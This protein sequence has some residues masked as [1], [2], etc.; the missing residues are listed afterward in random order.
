MGLNT[1]IKISRMIGFSDVPEVRNFRGKFVYNFFVRDELYNEKG[2]DR[3]QGSLEMISQNGQPLLIDNFQNEIDA[4]VIKSET[5]RF[6]ELDYDPA[7]LYNESNVSDLS[8]GEEKFLLKNKSLINDESSMNSPLDSTVA[9]TDVNLRRR[10]VGKLKILRDVMSSDD[11]PFTAKNLLEVLEEADDVDS[12]V[13]ENLLSKLSFTDK[14]FVNEIR[15]IDRDSTFAKAE[16]F[17][18]FTNVDRRVAA[19]TFNPVFD[20]NQAMVYVSDVFRKDNQQNWKAL[21]NESQSANFELNVKVLPGNQKVQK[22]VDSGLQFQ[23]TTAGYIIER[24]VANKNGVFDSKS[25]KTHYIDGA[26]R[27]KFIDTKVIYNKSYSYTVSAVYAVNF[28]A[29][30]EDDPKTT[31]N[32]AGTYKF[33][34]LVRSKRSKPVVIEAV[35]NIPP[36]APDGVLYRYNYDHGK[37][38]LINWQMPVGKQRDIKYFQVFRRRSIKE[39]F[40][41]IAELDFNDV[42]LRKGRK[43]LADPITK[44]ERVRKDRIYKYEFPRIFFNDARFDRESKFI[45]A[46]AAV[47]AHGLTSG[48]SAQTEVGFN[49]VKN[50]LTLST[51][52]RSGAA[53]QYPNFFIDP[54]LDDNF[55]VDSLTTDVMLSSKKERIHVFFDPDCRIAEITQDETSTLKKQKERTPVVKS[56]NKLGAEYVF[57]I[58]NVDRQK[59]K[60]FKIKITNKRKKEDLVDAPVDSV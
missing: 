56:M 46:I 45:Y 29:S 40:T 50:A 24:M 37:G 25:K 8:L 51:I 52:S 16:K 21:R 5:A 2:E 1:D 43:K 18:R 44:K 35:E 12:K 26:D 49:K 48:Y 39:P 41:C 34:A 42:I 31:E 9:K 22:S 36:A 7:V 6:V 20:K 23:A 30:I 3:F 33:T 60:N 15:Q 17:R 10:L 27:T 58:L 38:L 4:S 57:N 59:A 53:K 13:S 14:S 32:E 47:D 28:T 19:M 54:S 11:A 55:T